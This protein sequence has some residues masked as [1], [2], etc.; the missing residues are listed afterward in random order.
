MAIKIFYCENVFITDPGQT[1]GYWICYIGHMW[2]VGPNVMMKINRGDYI[3]AIDEST[4]PADLYTDPNVT[5][6]GDWNSGTLD[7]GVPM[8]NFI[9]DT[10][11]I[12]RGRINK[13]WKMLA[14]FGKFMKRITPPFSV[15]I[16]E[17]WITDG[18]RV[19]IDL[20]PDEMDI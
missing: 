10:F 20:T 4:V 16:M 17:Q 15:S 12:P 1:E 8:R 13:D 2:D 6:I 11:N 9:A 7:V 14:L 19:Y 18:K 3:V 5:E